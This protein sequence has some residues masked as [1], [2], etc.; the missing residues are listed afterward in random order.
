[1]R[2]LVR[3]RPTSHENSKSDTPTKAHSNEPKPISPVESDVVR[4]VQGVHEYKRPHE[5][6]ERD[7]RDSSLIH[8]NPPEIMNSLLPLRISIIVLSCRAGERAP[9]FIGRATLSV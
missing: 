2:L 1:M 7:D 3:K 8:Q 6:E 4:V 9:L 5:K